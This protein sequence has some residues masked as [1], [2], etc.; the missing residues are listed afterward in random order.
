VGAVAKGIGSI[1][2]TPTTSTRP[3]DA[4]A[5]IRIGELARRSGVSVRAL[6]Y[7]ETQGLLT[8][9]RSHSGQRYYA[10]AAIDKVRFS[11][12]CTPPG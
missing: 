2:L 8:P 10:K 3:A 12:T 7:Y 11:R 9:T 4:S 1:S 5:L 6:R